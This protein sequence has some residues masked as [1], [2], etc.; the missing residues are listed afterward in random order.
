[1]VA[2]PSW[3]I[4]RATYLSVWAEDG[5]DVNFKI[6]FGICYFGQNIQQAEL[7]KT[8]AVFEK[9]TRWLLFR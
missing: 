9:G 2:F 1:M 5:F 8:L 6:Y 7:A 3:R 4:H